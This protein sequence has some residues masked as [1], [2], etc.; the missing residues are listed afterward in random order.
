M[1]DFPPG[2]APQRSVDALESCRWR[3]TFPDLSRGPEA[4]HGSGRPLDT[5]R[6]HRDARELCLFR[7]GQGHALLP[8]CASARSGIAASRGSHTEGILLLDLAARDGDARRAAG[9]LS[10]FTRRVNVGRAAGGVGDL[11]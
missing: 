11:G 7:M 1:S 9:R 4:R 10:D 3:L 2:A 5:I 8:P 6:L